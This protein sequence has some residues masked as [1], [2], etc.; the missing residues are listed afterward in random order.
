MNKRPPKSP[1]TGDFQ[2][3]KAPH[4]GGWGVKKENLKILIGLQN[5]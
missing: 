5:T 4:L 1:E 3:N 2:S